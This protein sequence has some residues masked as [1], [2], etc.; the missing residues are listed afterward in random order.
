MSLKI[1]IMSEAGCWTIF[2][3]NFRHFQVKFSQ[4]EDLVKNFFL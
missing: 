3:Y 4:L 2:L 1:Q